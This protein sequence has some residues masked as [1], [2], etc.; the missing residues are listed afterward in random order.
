MT[1]LPPL[2]MWPLES[3]LKQEGRKRRF[4][5]VGIA[6]NLVEGERVISQGVPSRLGAQ[7]DPSR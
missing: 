7:A 1:L 5:V 3:G 4:T 2:W 6:K